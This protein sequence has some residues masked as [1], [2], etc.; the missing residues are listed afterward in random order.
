MNPLRNLVVAGSGTD[1]LLAAATLK[2][3]LPNLPVILVRDPQA[4]TG[5]A[6]E[7]TTPSVLQHLVHAVGL[8]GPDVHL[9]GRPVWTLGFKCLWGARGTF[10][11]SFDA[12][13][14]GNLSGFLAA[15]KGL[16]ASS[17]G[18]ALMAAGK[19]FPRDGA[20][21]FKPLEHITGLT[22]KTESLNA[23]LLRA[24]RVAGVILREGK[25]TGFTRD[26]DTLQ[27]EGGGSITADLYVDATGRDAHVATLAGN[28]AWTGYDLPCT[29]AATV[30]RRRGSEPIR[31]FTTLETLDSGWRWRV[32]HDDSVGMGMAW[33]PGFTS[34]DQA[35]SELVAKAG[36]SSLVPQVQAWDCGHRTAPWT[37]NVVAVGDA[38]GFLEPLSSL[39]LVHLIRHVQ[40]LLRI[41]VENDGII[42]E[43]SREL[44]NRVAAQAWD[45]TRDFH[46]IHY[47][48]NTASDSGFWKAARETKPLALAELVDLYQ[49][50][51]PSPVLESCI[52]GWP[53]VVGLESWMAALLGLGVPFR[54]HPE[55]PAS[56]QKV[57]DS[58]CE[59]RRQLARQAV[60]AELC[61]GAARN[62]VKPAPR[63]PLP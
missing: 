32:E 13:F 62:A 16:D 27:L 50:I 44:Y 47:R 51:G 34:D 30:L 2:R 42:G 37:G 12:P 28:A 3:A 39:R 53:G 21:A 56:E 57:W 20:N 8:Q 61:L 17:P 52:P 38:N 25:V 46:A 14:A 60:P 41:L 48:F 26:P 45:E 5:P 33:N 15:E 10:F 59:Q 63:V 24:C 19:L 35:C 7:S 55:I 36:D 11:R 31:P 29:R 18:A 54:H 4:A 40:W 43:R 9:Q 23:I 6:G 1:A 58:H 49:S 22:F